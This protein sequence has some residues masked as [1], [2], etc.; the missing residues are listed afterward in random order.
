MPREARRTRTV[1]SFINRRQC[2]Q[3]ITIEFWL[4]N[5]KQVFWLVHSNMIWNLVG[6]VD[7]PTGLY[8]SLLSGQALAKLTIGKVFGSSRAEKRSNVYPDLETCSTKDVVQRGGPVDVQLVRESHVLQLRVLSCPLRGGQVRLLLRRLRRAILRLLQERKT[9]FNKPCCVW[10]W[11]V[12]IVFTGRQIL[13]ITNAT[14]NGGWMTAATFPTVARATTVP[15]KARMTLPMKKAIK[16]RNVKAI[17]TVVAMEETIVETA[18]ELRAYVI[19]KVEALIAARIS[20]ALL[21][22]IQ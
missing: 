17:L 5:T 16:R 1:P 22:C 21:A 18:A 8:M 9:A 10:T 19:K 15:L 11:R 13:A 14:G 3:L 20:V 2:K 7:K 12:E 6:T 4:V